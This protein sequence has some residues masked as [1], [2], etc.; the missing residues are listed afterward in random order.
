MAKDLTK[1]VIDR[2]N[3]LNNPYALEEIHRATR[4]ECFVF[5]GKAVL[6]KDQVADFFAVTPR[7]I[8]NYIA[9]YEDELQR[10]GYEVLR[11]NRLKRFKLEIME[12]HVN[13]NNFVN[14]KIPQLGVFDFRAF[15]NLAMLI[16]E[17]EP[18]RLLRSTILDIVIDTINKK[19][20][21]AHLLWSV[22]RSKISDPPYKIF[23]YRDH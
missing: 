17:S 13:E 20:G 3:I 15:L 1:S 7:T 11:G 5:E 19:T 2:Q 10:N 16:T 18:A 6:L 4:I 8:D 12:Q 9:R 22:S 23:T 21:G 14:I